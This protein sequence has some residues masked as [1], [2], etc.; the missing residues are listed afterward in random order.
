MT[1]A[2]ARQRR[3]EW[4]ATHR[5]LLEGF[6]TRESEVT[7]LPSRAANEYHT[8]HRQI[9]RLMR[10]AGLVSKTTYYLDVHLIPMVNKLRAR[11]G[12]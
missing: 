11:N 5:E 10:D 7:R 9:V 12:A 3:L 4:L 2:E 8:R 1:R 6:P